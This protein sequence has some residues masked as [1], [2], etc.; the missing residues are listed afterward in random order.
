MGE[1]LGRAMLTTNIHADLTKYR[2]KV[3]GGLT[4]R[5][6]TCIVLALATAI[7]LG[8]WSWFALGADSD[9]IGIVI[10]IAVIPTR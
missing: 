3:I 2:P 9:A 10:F 1:R 5:T 8:A 6:F 7:A 4:M